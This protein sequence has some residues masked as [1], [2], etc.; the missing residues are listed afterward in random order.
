MKHCTIYRNQ[1]IGIGNRLKQIPVHTTDKQHKHRNILKKHTRDTRILPCGRIHH[2]DHGQANIHI[3][4]HTGKSNYRRTDLCTKPNQKTGQHFFHDDSTI[5]PNRLIN[6]CFMGK[7]YM[8]KENG[9]KNSKSYF[10]S[11]RCIIHPEKRSNG[12]KTGNS[13]YD[14][15]K[16]FQLHKRKT[17]FYHTIT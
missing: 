10:Y 3:N 13:H 16:I 17:V 14:E 11:S 2:T 9:N 1:S 15:Q 4:N 7:G 6:Q 12:N 5:S 8:I